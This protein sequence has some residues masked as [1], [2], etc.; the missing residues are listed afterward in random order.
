M[1]RLISID[2]KSDFGFLKKPDTNEPVSLTFNMLHKPA[3]LGIFGAILGISGYKTYLNLKQKKRGYLP[4]FFMKLKDLKVGIQPLRDGV[5]TSNAFDK[6]I[7]QYNNGVGYASK[8]QG[9][10]L[11]ITEQ[12]LVNPSFRIFLLLNDDD[13]ESQLFDSLRN[14]KAEYLPYL[15]KNDF[16][17]WWTNFKEYQFEEF[18]FQES[19]KM[20]SIF[21]KNEQILKDNKSISFSMADL[22][23]SPEPTFMLFEQLPIG[24]NENLFQYDYESF[25]YTNVKFNSDF[26]LPNLYQL[27][28][29][30]IIQVF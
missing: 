16:S 22:L 4:E 29:E 26:K 11:I 23:D 17:L 20:D 19:F 18:D 15:G 1:A 8:E 28:G 2:L 25:S 9:G 27:D 24:Y 30:Q 21:I 6:T 5:P 12:T 14:S 3:L 10:N 7:I 13:L